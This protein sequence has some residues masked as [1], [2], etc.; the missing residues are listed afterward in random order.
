MENRQIC[1][2]LDFL[3]FSYFG[4]TFSDE[5]EKIL[6]AAVKKAYIDATMRAALVLKRKFEKCDTMQEQYDKAYQAS[7]HQRKAIRFILR[8][9]AAGAVADAV[10]RLEKDTRFDEWHTNLC[11]KLV[12]GAEGYE[13]F[14]NEYNS[15]LE[16]ACPELWKLEKGHK[17][18]FTYGN[19]QKLVNMTMKNLYII[20]VISKLYPSE[21]SADHWSEKYGWIIEQ[22]NEYHIPMDSYIFD[23]AGI[24]GKTWSTVDEE[25]YTGLQNEIKKNIKSLDDEGPKWIK[26]AKKYAL[27][28][29]KQTLKQFKKVF[30][31]SAELCNRIDSCSSNS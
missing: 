12:N 21:P 14:D 5:P 20:T 10:S 31:N 18:Y 24:R 7:E 26:Q 13:G 3:M 2:A 8:E 22:A 17:Q 11:Q 19:A 23:I 9:E 16:S 6:F 1:N 29:R 4:I 28:N 15:L 30:V 27:E 25:E